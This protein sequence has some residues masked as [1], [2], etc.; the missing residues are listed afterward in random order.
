MF[1]KLNFF[2]LMEE[3]STLLSTYSVLINS[4]IIFKEAK[5]IYFLRK[6]L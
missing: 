3:S 2:L 6:S 1:K 4:N 5:F